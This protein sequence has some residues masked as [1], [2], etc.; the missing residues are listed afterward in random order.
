MLYRNW[1][2]WGSISALLC[3]AIGAFGAHALE[4][5]ER[6]ATYDT[7]VQYHMLHAMG[8]LAV[9]LAG[10]RLGRPAFSR[11]AGRLFAVGTVLFS[12]SLYILSI[13]G[14]TWLGA[15]TPLGGLAFLAGWGLLAGSAF[16]NG[17]GPR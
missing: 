11:W 5:G 14:M 3:V 4:L 8:M 10:D 1:I 16:S 13:T 6:A 2:A 9:G 7:G 15:I 12:G 17:T